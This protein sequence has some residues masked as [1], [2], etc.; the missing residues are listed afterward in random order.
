MSRRNGSTDP[1]LYMGGFR[2]AARYRVLTA[3]QTAEMLGV[4]PSRVRQLV[5]TKD[6]EPTSRIGRDL[7]FLLSDVRKLLKERKR[8][9]APRRPG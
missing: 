8:I 5:M 6:L 4:S 1:V 3:A 9:A 7:L 2:I